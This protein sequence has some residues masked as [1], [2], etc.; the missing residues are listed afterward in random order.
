VFQKV[1]PV[2]NGRARFL[3]YFI[4]VETVPKVVVKAANSGQAFGTFIFSTHL[5]HTQMAFARWGIVEK[6]VSIRKKTNPIPQEFSDYEEAAEFWDSHD[7]TEYLQDSRPVKVVSEFRGRH[8]EIEIDENVALA[9]RKAARQKGITP[10]R[11]ASD[12]LRQRLT[13]PS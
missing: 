10:S 1:I 9:L 11:L 12:L 6:K 13:P 8:Y 2:K 4:S 5:K 3:Q 7:T